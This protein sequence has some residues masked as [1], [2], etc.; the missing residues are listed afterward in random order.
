MGVK[1]AE[2]RRVF[3]AISRSPLVT[4]LEWPNLRV[5]RQLH[6][7]KRYRRSRKRMPVRS[8]ANER[9]NQRQPVVGRYQRLRIRHRTKACAKDEQSYEKD[10]QPGGTRVRAQLSRRNHRSCVLYFSRSMGI[11]L[12]PRIRS[13][14]L[15]TG[16]K[17]AALS[18]HQVLISPQSAGFTLAGVISGAQIAVGRMYMPAR[19]FPV[20]SHA[21][22]VRNQ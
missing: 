5:R 20:I 17:A 22:G 14:L 21:S 15:P 3:I 13:V 8:C 19:K 10:W 4:L 11:R 1:K 18:G 2:E 12:T 7:P 9:I 6:H 16:G